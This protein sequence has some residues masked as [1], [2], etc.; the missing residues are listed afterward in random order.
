MRHDHGKR[1]TAPIRCTG[2]T[3]IELLVVIAIIAILAAM[4]LPALSGAK[5]RAQGVSCI[6][7]LKQLQ[8][9]W[10]MYADDNN[11]RVVRNG[12]GQASGSD[13]EN[14]VYGRL[15]FGVNNPDNT[16]TSFLTRA[17]LAPYSKGSVGIYKCPADTSKAQILSSKLPR[18]R[19]VSMNGLVGLPEG[20]QVSRTQG[21]RK[22]RKLSDIARP[23][24]SDLWVV[25]D[26]HPST[27]ED[28]WAGVE[29]GTT[30]WVDMP[31]A[32]HGGSSGLGFADGHAEI[33]RWRDPRTRLAMAEEERGPSSLTG[34]GHNNQDLVWLKAHT[35]S[36]EN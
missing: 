26:E 12:S 18:V 36:S 2:F 19:S 13:L 22:F 4:L 20:D 33:H 34:L 30:E 8:L 27:I 6:S 31:S 14:W 17:K 23:H 35:S 9:A 25:W 3:L 11:D 28:G 10:I 21:W 7:N 1:P 24:A 16:N 32:A 5:L 15:G 29:M